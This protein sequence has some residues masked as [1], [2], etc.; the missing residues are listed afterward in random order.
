[1]EIENLILEDDARGYFENRSDLDAFIVA[2]VDDG[3]IFY[4]CAVNPDVDPEREFSALGWCAQLVTRIEDLGFDQAM[5][6]DGWQHR[7]DGRWQLWGRA[8]DLPPVD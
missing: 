3:D 5:I 1:M 7:G 8:V 6:T 2:G 4:G